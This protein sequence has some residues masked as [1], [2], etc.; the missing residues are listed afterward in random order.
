[1]DLG[2]LLLILALASAITATPA[3]L[4]YARGRHELAGTARMFTAMLAVAVFAASAFQMQNILRHQFQYEYIANF[5]DR[6]LPPLLLAATFWAGQSGSFLLWALWSALFALVLMVGLQR[7][8]WEPFVLTPYLLVT[9][10]ITA[11]TYA[12]DPFKLHAPVP[13]DGQGLN[14]LLQNYWMAI[15][16]PILFA[17]FTT[18]AAPFAF[19]VAALWKR[20]YDGWVP[21]ARPWTLLAWACLGTGLALGGFWAYESLGWG[22]FWGW[23]PV[24]NSSLVPWLFASALLHGLVMQGARGSL[25]RANLVLAITGYA[26]VVYSTFLTRSGILGNFSVHSFVEL[27]LMGY[28]VVFVAGI[29]L[30]GLGLL[31]WR[32]RDIHRRVLYQAVLSREFGLL[33]SITLFVIIALVVGTGTSLPVITLLPV[34]ASQASLD[35]S[36]YGPT[37]APFGLLLLVTMAVGPLLGWQRAKYGALLGALRW[38]VILTGLTFGICMV[39]GIVYPVAVLFLCAAVFAVATNAVVVSRIW[40]AGPLKLGGYVCHVGVGL[41]FVGIVGTTVYKQTATL[42]LREDEPQMVFGRLWTLRGL[43]VPPDDVLQR[44]AMEVEVTDPRSGTTWVAYAPYYVFAKTGQLTIH[45][46]IQSG[47]FADLYL[48][49]S[50]YQ[51]PV[52]IEPGVVQLGMERASTALGYTLRFKQFEVP[53]REAMQQGEAPTEIGATV[54]V[55][56]PDGRTVT[57]TP[58]LHL[59]AG[60]LPVAQPA[61]LPGGATLA[62]ERMDPTNQLVTL[63]FGGVDLSKA[64]P[65]EFKARAFVE[66]SREPGIKLVWGGIMLALLGGLLAV[67]RR[68]REAPSADR[69]AKAKDAKK[70]RT[71]PTPS[72]RREPLPQASI[73]RITRPEREAQ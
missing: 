39:L 1:M 31:V 47:W 54:E 66:V 46:A 57:V 6:S 7:S 36:F 21:M 23:D 32:W 2:N 33:V 68:W 11:I 15:H 42:H 49:P 22:G 41:L 37:V 35:L 5:S 38:P 28:L 59:A 65:A 14:P 56:A 18:M 72:G 27:G 25:Q 30:L 13:A 16:P 50:D 3:Y 19:A 40:R 4:L 9:L 17:G 53:Q 73:T 58:M 55:V 48:A 12:S 61:T 62:I 8:S 44:T 34:F 67:V 70:T 52:Q 24:E 45:P 64:D 69:P 29:A 20:D 10:A 43:T 63:R 26:M 71:A 60:T 51:P